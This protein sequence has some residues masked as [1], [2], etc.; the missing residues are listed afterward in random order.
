[1][2]HLFVLV[3]LFFVALRLIT[4]V[5][6]GFG[7]SYRRGPIGYGSRYGYRRQGFGGG[8]FTILG[9]VALDRLFLGRRW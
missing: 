8:L 6:F 4:R 5:L 9:L 7:R 1:M 3:I 2:I